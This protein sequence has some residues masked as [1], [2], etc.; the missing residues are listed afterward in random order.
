MT[1]LDDETSIEKDQMGGSTAI[2]VESITKIESVVYGTTWVAWL[3]LGS[4]I[5]INTACSIMWMSA[6]S[7]PIAVSQ[8]L[9][10][11]F[12]QLNWLSNASAIINS[13]FSVVTGWSY[14]RY[15]IKANVQ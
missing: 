7:S 6:C 2:E 1:Y 9:N 14:E 5:L 4:I 8:W 13:I 10:I 12:S 3:Q 15:G 11:S